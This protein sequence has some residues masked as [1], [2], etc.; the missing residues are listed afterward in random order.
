MSYAL[1]TQAI[2]CFK[3]Y[4]GKF[5]CPGTGNVFG[6]DS[7]R[8][9][10]KEPEAGALQGAKLKSGQSN[11]SK[12]TEPA[13]AT[14]NGAAAGHAARKE[15]IDH[16]TQHFERYSHSRAVIHQEQIQNIEGHCGLGRL[17]GQ[18]W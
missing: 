16:F 5:D 11:G 18:P 6:K 2:A 8:L 1:T 3:I 15:T 12:T 7:A 9:Q 14:P 17:S 10:A 13:A 4:A